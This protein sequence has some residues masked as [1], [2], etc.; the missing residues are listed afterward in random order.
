[1]KDVPGI[2]AFPQAIPELLSE[3]AVIAARL[4]RGVRDFPHLP[5]KKQ[6]LPP[7][8]TVESG[9]AHSDYARSLAEFGHP[10]ALFRSGG[11]I[12]ERLIPG[13]DSRDGM[14]CYPLFSCRDW[15][16]LTDDFADL[17]DELVSL[18]LVADPF[19]N[20][21]K[22]ILS[23]TFKD[24]LVP[25]KEHFA[26]DLREP[27]GEFASPHHQRNAGAALR[28]IEVEH[29]ASAEVLLDEW[30][31][32]YANLSARHTITGIAAFSRDSF[33]RQLRVPGMTAFRAVHGGQT[34]GINLWYAGREVGYYHLG[35]YS[36]QGYRLRASFALFWRAIEHFAAAGLKWLDLGAGAGAA[37]DGADGLTRFKRGW[38]NTTRTAYLCG[39]ILDRPKY[40]R[41]VD[42]KDPNDYF[43][44][45]RRGEFV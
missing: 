3:N 11:W 37:N 21:T 5:M 42:G 43:P 36:E 20:F 28:L 10:R 8:C 39:R 34:I 2:G 32:L 19:G 15:S 35:A 24:L 18:V 7:T 30:S 16:W 31:L 29:A 13:T 14:G 26:I 40:E 25:F 4:P 9:Y 6:T 41:L 22:E 12:L 45:Y 33:A 17:G 1:M 27:A 23:E 38:A 44:A